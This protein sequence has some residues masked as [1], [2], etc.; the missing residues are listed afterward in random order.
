MMSHRPKL[1]STGWIRGRRT[2]SDWS[3]T[4]LRN[5]YSIGSWY[6]YCKD[7]DC[8]RDY[9]SRYKL[10]IMLCEIASLVTSPVSYMAEWWKGRKRD[11]PSFEAGIN[12]QKFGGTTT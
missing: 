3:Q 11:S 12:I 7:R 4:D 2:H 10:V 6:N 8:A 1:N 5:S 9:V